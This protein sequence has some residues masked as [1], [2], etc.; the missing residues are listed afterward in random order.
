MNSFQVDFCDSG[1]QYRFLLTNEGEVVAQCL[2]LMYRN[3]RAKV[4]QIDDVFVTEENRGN[5]FGKSLMREVIKFA[6]THMVDSIEL[7]VNGDNAVARN[8]YYDLGFEETSKVFCRKI[9]NKF[10][11]RR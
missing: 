2:G 5:G 10:E 6:E 8:L 1:T 7:T 3:K 11:D 4:M 9:L